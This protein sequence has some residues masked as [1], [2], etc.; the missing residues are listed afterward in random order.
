MWKICFGK[1]RN[2]MKTGWKTEKKMINMKRLFLSLITLTI[3]ESAGR[4]DAQTLYTAPEA[5]TKVKN[6]ISVGVNPQVELISIVETIS[7]YPTVLGFLMAKDSSEYKL[8]VT[9]HFTP[10]KDHQVIHMFDRLS[11]QPGMLNFSA[12]SNI[13]LYTDRSLN[14]REDIELDDFVINRAGGKDSLHIFLELIRDFAIQSSFNKF[15]HDHQDFYLMISENTI[16]NLGSID[17]ISELENFYGKKQK[18]Y[19]IVLVSLY[20]FH[21]FGNS[22]LC[23]NDQREI[24]NTMGPQAVINNVQFFG[25]EHYMKYMIRHEFSHPF[26]NPLTEKYWDYIK[27]YTDNFDS[28]P[29]AHKKVCGEWQE[30]INEF[31]IRA[32]TTQIAYNES[33]ETGLQVYEKE[34]SRGVSHLDILLEKIKYYQSRRERYP[35][36]DSYY[37]NILD[38]FKE[39]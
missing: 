21:G 7:K 25:D 3:V 36:L 26:V 8:D 20:N 29:D 16:N 27:D 32:I 14:L 4:L 10:Y 11:Q 30:C 35:T 19:N 6:Q 12:P 13:M 37:L 17:Y 28:I 39:K 5:I 24:Y 33:E 34:K 31:T 22:L 1:V 9:E 38:V 23:S 18:S 2:R 15:Y